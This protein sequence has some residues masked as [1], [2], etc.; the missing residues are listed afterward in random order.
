M[1]SL[2]QQR[3]QPVGVGLT[4]GVQEGDDLPFGGGGPQQPGPDK[5]L[6]LLGPQDAH[7]GQPHHVLLQGHLQVLCRERERETEAA[8]KDGVNRLPG[9]RERG[10]N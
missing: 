1:A 8:S 4:V 5:P 2:T 6:P 9:G 7:F 3:R 10:S